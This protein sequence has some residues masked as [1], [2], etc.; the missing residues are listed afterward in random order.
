MCALSFIFRSASSVPSKFSYVRIY[1]RYSFTRGLSTRLLG[2]VFIRSR[3]I[4]SLIALP[5]TIDY[6]ITNKL[7]ERFP[8]HDTTARI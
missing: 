6:A 2:L 3:E 8:G 1:A 4:L 7:R 5:Y